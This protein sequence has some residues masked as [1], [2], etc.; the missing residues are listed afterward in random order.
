[1]PPAKRTAAQNRDAATRVAPSDRGAPRADEL[2]EV[3]LALDALVEALQ[4]NSEAAR[5]AIKRAA[6]IRRRREQGM[7]YRDIVISESR[8]LIV[9]MTRES[10]ERLNECGARLRRA[11]ARALHADGLTMDAI[12]A[13]FGVSRQRVSVLLQGRERRGEGT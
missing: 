12:A 5:Q 2:D 4:A 9:E 11:E 10:L 13:M 6:Y 3:L 1:M 8:P 7:S